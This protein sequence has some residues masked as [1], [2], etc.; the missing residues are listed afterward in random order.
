MSLPAVKMVFIDA[1][2]WWAEWKDADYTK[3]W[4][5]LGQAT[6]IDYRT[7]NLNGLGNSALYAPTFYRHSEGANMCFYDG[8]VK[9][10][11]K[12]DI[13]NQDDFAANPKNPGIWVADKATWKK[14]NPY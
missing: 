12:Q 7:P 11:K 9:Y 5:M 14:Y 4:D 3:G 6:S 8:H 13:F 10:M 1:I 2:D